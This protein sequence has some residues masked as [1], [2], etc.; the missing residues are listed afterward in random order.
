MLATAAAVS[1]KKP[2]TETEKGV[3]LAPS[4]K[5]LKPWYSKRSSEREIE[6]ETSSS[7]ATFF[8]SK[9]QDGEAD[10]EEEGIRKRRRD[11]ERKTIMHDPLYSISRQ[12]ASRSASS[13]EPSSSRVPRPPPHNPQQ[14]RLSRESSERQRALDLIKRRKREV[15]GMGNA[16][17][18]TVF[19]DPDSGY[20][21]V[22]NRREVDEA[23]RVRNQ[24]QKGWDGGR[25]WE[26]SEGR[27]ER[28][29]MHVLKTK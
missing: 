19:D 22:F 20:R 7:S 12:L 8:Q 1:K 23:H 13:S 10:E 3:A 16:T 28:D 18:T 14:A 25:R 17:P 6:I 27:S 29:R 9:R 11:E 24:S 5:D 21:D 2:T 15:A 4:A 26:R